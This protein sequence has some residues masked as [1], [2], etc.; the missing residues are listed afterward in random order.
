MALDWKSFSGIYIRPGYTDMRKAINGLALLVQD[1]MQFNVFEHNVFLFCGRR[2]R[3]LKVLYWD[4]NGF[5]LWQKRLEKDRY[6][7]PKTE[8][9]AQQLTTE[10]L[11]LLLQG[12]DFTA[13]H[14]ELKY[15]SVS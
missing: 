4:G 13:R 5:C 10:D 14:K 2:K 6:V 1:E 15:F 8:Q 3:S 9:Q 11:D 12:L 7:W